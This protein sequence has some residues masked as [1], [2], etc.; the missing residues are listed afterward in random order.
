MHGDERL[1]AAQRELHALLAGLLTEAAGDGHVR[2]DV[3]AEELASYWPRAL[4]A[5]S[6]LPAGPAGGRLVTVVLDGLRPGESGRRDGS[7]VR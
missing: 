4:E 1:V 5:A 2:G 7:P 6:D 3:P